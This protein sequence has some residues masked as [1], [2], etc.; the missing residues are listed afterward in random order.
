MIFTLLGIA[1]PSYSEMV[2][3]ARIVAAIGDI[4]QMQSEIEGYRICNGFFPK[5]LNDAGLADR[6]DPWGRPFQYLKIAGEKKSKVGGCRKDK[7]LVPLNSDYD[8]Y[9]LGR[10][11]SSVPPLTAQSS[12]DDIIRANNGGFIGLAR[13]Y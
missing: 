8:L 10:D 4:K 7:N 5:T 12:R 11:G 6:V 2:N 1:I 9:S 13:N 3:T